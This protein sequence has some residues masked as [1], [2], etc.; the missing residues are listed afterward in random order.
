MS[1]SWT[2]RR[3]GWYKLLTSVVTGVADSESPNRAG[4]GKTLECL[5][6]AAEPEQRSD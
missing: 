1:E 2:D 4:M 5:G 3:P 6:V